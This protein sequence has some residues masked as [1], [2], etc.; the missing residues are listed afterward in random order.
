MPSPCITFNI[1]YLKYLVFGGFLFVF[2]FH[3]GQKKNIS[4]DSKVL[5]PTCDLRSY[6]HEPKILLSMG[7]DHTYQNGYCTNTGI[8]HQ[9]NKTE[10]WGT[11][12]DRISRYSISVLS[13]RVVFDAVLSVSH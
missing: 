6:I 5:I 13:N 9:T 7:K 2:F 12:L 10:M 1:P 3:H 11:V 4:K 8:R